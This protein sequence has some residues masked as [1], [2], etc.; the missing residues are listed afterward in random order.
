MLSGAVAG[1]DMRAARIRAQ[2]QYEGLIR[3]YPDR[4][5]QHPPL[6]DIFQ[7]SYPLWE[8]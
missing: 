3:K 6:E 8:V 4:S 5:W 2:Q 7:S 1:I